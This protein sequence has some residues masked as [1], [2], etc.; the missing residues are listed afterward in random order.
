MRSIGEQRSNKYNRVYI[1]Q[2]DGSRRAGHQT[3]NSLRRL[4]STGIISDSNCP[5]FEVEFKSE[6]KAQRILY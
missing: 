1:G 6:Y 4:R 3:E 5:S 2:F